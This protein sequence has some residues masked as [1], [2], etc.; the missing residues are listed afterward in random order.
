MTGMEVLTILI[1]IAILLSLFIPAVVDAIDKSNQVQCRK[2][3][4]KIGC[5]LDA[6]KKQN[7]SLPASLRNS[8]HPLLDHAA[9]S[10]CPVSG[11]AYDSFYLPGAPES[12][13]PY[14]LGCPHSMGQYALF[15]PGT[16][17]VSLQKSMDLYADG[18]LVSNLG[19]EINAKKLQMGDGS[20]INIHS[21]TLFIVASF[22]TDES[23][24]KSLTIVRMLKK[25]APQSISYH[26]NNIQQCQSQFVVVT[27]TALISSIKSQFR[28]NVFHNPE[29]ATISTSASVLTGEIKFGI[30]DERWE[31][32]YPGENAELE[33]STKQVL[34][35]PL[36]LGLQFANGIEIRQNPEILKRQ[37]DAIFQHDVALDHQNNKSAILDDVKKQIG[38]SM[39]LANERNNGTFKY[40]FKKN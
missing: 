5:L 22:Y 36:L 2:N 3:L 23:Q 33:T 38:K 24:R 16:Q 27:P 7:L 28:I 1:I 17:D 34:E 8:I 6:C 31:S 30:T 11:E 14:V 10:C 19:I 18:M 25:N 4:V 21:G 35:D 15:R 39:M 37:F 13:L 29:K 40:Q 12:G 20:I 9:Q 26:I 32:I